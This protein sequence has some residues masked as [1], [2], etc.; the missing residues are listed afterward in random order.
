MKHRILDTSRLQVA[1]EKQDI[2][3]VVIHDHHVR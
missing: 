1:G 2:I 3:V